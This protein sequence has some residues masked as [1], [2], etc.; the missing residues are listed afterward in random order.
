M[1]F[2]SYADALTHL[3]AARK[4][5]IELDL[6]NFA[7]SV[8]AD[9]LD[10]VSQLNKD[11]RNATGMDV[12]P[13]DLTKEEIVALRDSYGA[14]K[15]CGKIPCIK[16]VLERLKLGLKEAKDYVENWQE[17]KLYKGI[18]GQ[19]HSHDLYNF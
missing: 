19:W 13:D 11:V 15:W 8:R 9:M 18:D 10:L 17:R 7:D 2:H 4:I 1:T 6:H 12:G 5:L 14:E 3:D 16:L